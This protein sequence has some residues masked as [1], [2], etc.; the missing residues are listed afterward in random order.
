MLMAFATGGPVDGPPWP[1]HPYRI[2]KLAGGKEA[3][4]PMCRYFSLPTR[5]LPTP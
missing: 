4:K 5:V 2:L 1:L 3:A